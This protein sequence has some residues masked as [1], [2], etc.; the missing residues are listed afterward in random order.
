MFSIL[1]FSIL[2]GYCNIHCTVVHKTLLWLVRINVHQ[3]L[4]NWLWKSNVDTSPL[5]QFSKFIHFLSACWFLG[6]NL[7]NFISPAWKLDNPY[8]YDNDNGTKDLYYSTKIC[9][10]MLGF[11]FLLMFHL[12]IESVKCKHPKIMDRLNDNITIIFYTQKYQV[13]LKNNK[14]RISSAGQRD[15]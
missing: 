15:W 4:E 12:F 9:L 11:I 2:F 3:S 13:E 1:V 8:N 10:L 6:K 7:S 14:N 5:H